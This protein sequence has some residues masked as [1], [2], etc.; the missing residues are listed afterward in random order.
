MTSVLER[1]SNGDLHTTTFYD[2]NWKPDESR[3]DVDVQQE[4]NIERFLLY[5][6][7]RFLISE[8]L[9]SG[10]CDNVEVNPHYTNLKLTKS[11]KER[12]RFEALT[13]ADIDNNS[14]KDS[15]MSLYGRS[16]IIFCVCGLIAFSSKWVWDNKV[17]TDTTPA[18]ITQKTN[19]QKNNPSE[20]K[21]SPT[22]KNLIK[23]DKP[24]T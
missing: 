13:L 7:I 17:C 3:F 19:L 9:V 10:D 5:S 16:I 4:A 24:S 23:L 15:F 22:N 12:L 8:K 21:S 18:L 6:Q 1:I 20:S 2:S 14:G 11:G